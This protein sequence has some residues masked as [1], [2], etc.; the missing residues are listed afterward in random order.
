M[1]V[2]GFARWAVKQVPKLKQK[3]ASNEQSFDNVYLDFNGVV[4]GCIDEWGYPQTVEE[5]LFKLVE[6]SLELLVALSKP[7][8]LLF[9]GL[10]GVAPRAK[11]NQQ[12]SR[13]FRSAQEK[14]KTP[15][16]EAD[17]LDD[18]MLDA[19]A[20]FDRNAITPGTP[21]ML[22][23]T[24]RLEKWAEA[25][26]SCEHLSGVTIV[27]SG[28]RHPGEGEHKIMEVIRR[29]PERSHL[30]FSNDADLIFLG[31]VSPAEDVF[32]LR[33]KMNSK[34][35]APA[36]ETAVQ[37]D[38][39]AAVAQFAQDYELFNLASLRAYLAKQFPDCSLQSIVQDFVAICCLVGN[40]F[41]P[42]VD[43]IDIY[44]GGIEKLLKAYHGIEPHEKGHLVAA[45][46]SLEVARWRDLLGR[47]SE[48]EAESLLESMGLGRGA[49]Q[50]PYRGPGCP[51]PDWDG[52]SVHVTGAGP[53]AKAEDMLRIFSKGEAL[54]SGTHEVK[55]KKENHP[56]TWL[57]RFDDPK[58]AV[59]ALTKKYM[60]HSKELSVK[61]IVPSTLDLVE[62]PQEPFVGK[63]WQP[64]I[65]AAVLDCFEYWLGAKNLPNDA[66]L[67]R[68]VRQREDRFVPIK[69]MA[70][71]KRMKLYIQNIKEIARILRT[72][73]VLEVQ[74]D[75]EEAMVRAVE[76]YST[77]E[78]ESPAVLQAQRKAMECMVASDYSGAV[79]SLKSMHYEKRESLVNG[80]VGVSNSEAN[81]SHQ[82]LVGVQWVLKY[83]TEGCSSWCW[84]FPGHF[85]PLCTSLLDAL[86][87]PLTR[88][89]AAAP[90]SPEMQL[91]AVLPAQSSPLL[92]ERLRGLLTDAAS[93]IVDFYPKTFTIYKKPSDKEWQGTVLL[94]FVDEERLR[95]ALKTLGWHDEVTQQPGRAF[96][97]LPA[98]GPEQSKRLVSWPFEAGELQVPGADA[99]Q[100]TAAGG[101]NTPAA[102]AQ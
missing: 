84:Y 3:L 38:P 93:P 29:C 20:S 94:P 64:A 76:D 70:S 34:A 87:A 80:C 6:T 91:L 39:S 14:R 59:A 98:D 17:T 46:G 28:D 83:Y 60:F 37:E 30:I 31:L 89:P 25:N 58:K 51:T 12:R 8:K 13:R 1:G 32:L 100:S 35:Q 82:F 42:C 54:V 81:L 19:G 9:I 33:Q 74:G 95:A 78:E 15:D 101:Y 88:P 11:M 22:R 27:V 55:P 40:D 36:A 65:D 10:D 71:F 56:S 43:A 99:L 96:H 7:R 4:H 2:P 18:V 72:S 47:F 21:F 75:D 63:D 53:K 68:Q 48:M 66:F 50:P 41:L 44:D 24:A 92:P 61:W 5:T 49:P 97:S 102:P 85:A 26:A 45:D 73:S 16:T 52:V 69:V 77:R 67:R 62:S 90:F 57:V 23:L 79:R 86:E